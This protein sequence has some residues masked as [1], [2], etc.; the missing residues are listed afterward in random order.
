MLM[1]GVAAVHSPPVI[2]E[3]VADP[4]NFERSFRD[5]R[6]ELPCV[7]SGDPPPS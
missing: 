1:F 7:A 6:V 4:E 5:E 3:P 2:G